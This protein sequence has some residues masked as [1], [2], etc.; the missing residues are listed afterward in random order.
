MSNFISKLSEVLYFVNL[1]LPMK[2][3]TFI[4]FVL[5]SLFS[6]G[7]SISNYVFSNPQI[8]SDNSA[9]GLD[10]PRIVVPESGL[11]LVMWTSTDDKKI[12][13]S[14]FNGT[15]FDEPQSILPDGF[16]FY[17]NQN[18][19]PE[20]DCNENFISIVFHNSLNGV[21]SV[22]FIFS[23]DGGITF[24]EPIKIVEEQNFIE[25]AGIHIDSNNNPVLT[26][27]TFISAD[28]VNQFVSFGQFTDDDSGVLFNLPV[29]A[30]KNTPG[31]PCECCLGS[32]ASNDE[33]VIF[34]YRNN[35]NNVRN[36][37]SCSYN[38]LN[39]EFNSGFLIDSYN[40]SLSVCPTE[41]PKSY[42]TNNFLVN[43]FKSYAY[44]PARIA[45]SIVDLNNNQIV[46]ESEVDWEVGY[47]VQS[48]PE[49]A[50][51][52]NTFAIVWKEFR[53]YNFD[54]FVS[55][56][57]SPSSEFLPNFETS[58]SISSSPPNSQTANDF[59]AVDIEEYNG[60]FHVVYL[61]YND[62]IIFYRNLANENFANSLNLVK[63]KN[64]IGTFD[65]YGR[66][67]FK[68]KFEIDIFDDGTAKK[69][70][71]LD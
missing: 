11:P 2:K 37:Y 43:S 18:Y 25:G 67:S 55:I 17:G 39:Q 54:V 52:D 10:R 15:D 45:T 49:I 58:L 56:G 64:T 22:Y 50:G 24:S 57:S 38:F 70:F 23:K 34:S 8:V 30:N 51:N 63:E 44:S 62:N 42:L 46:Y 12:Y 3:K 32:L 35:I 29:I 65:M 33:N 26:Y 71:V 60:V 59:T 69:K 1:K 6:Y 66:P 16:D 31:V 27:E 14:L 21:N 36:M 68:G 7:Q 28:S 9:F 20:I 19:G 5:I 53:Y 13:V 47:G 48:L 61:D 4:C 40:Q 41:G